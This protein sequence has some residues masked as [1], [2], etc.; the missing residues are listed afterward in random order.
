M[1][2]PLSPADAQR[3]AHGSTVERLARTGYFVKGLLY[4]LIGILALL[5]ALG[6]GGQT[7]GTRGAI[8]TLA[9]APFGHVLLW[10]IAIGLVGYA[11]WRFAQSILDVEDKGSDAEGATKRLGLAGSGLIYGGLAV[12]T[13]NLLLGDGTGESGGSGAASWTARLMEQPFGVWLVGMA[14]VGTIALGLYQLYRAWAVTFED[15]LKTREMSAAQQTWAVRISRF[16]IGARGV[17][18][19]LMGTFVIQAALQADPQEARGLDGALEALEGQPHGP[20]L[21]GLAA[22][23]LVAYGV[24][25]LVNARF[26]RIG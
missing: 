1:H 3:A 6:Q 7:T 19:V 23:G 21:L 26:R 5:T 9:D 16:G 11:L 13:F 24:Y 18:F 10:L 25:C 15:K 4:G 14:G 20:Y 8:R 2:T 17:V 12:S 22:L